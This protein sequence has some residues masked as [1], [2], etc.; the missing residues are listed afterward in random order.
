MPRPT[1][2]PPKD[3][4]ARRMRVALAE[5]DLKDFEVAEQASVSPEWLGSVKQGVTKNPPLDKLRAVAKVLGKP[6]SYFTAPLGYVPIEESGD[7]LSSIE[8]TILSEPTLSD[9]RKQAG[10]VVMRDLFAR[11]KEQVS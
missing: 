11:S 3:T 10:L 6:T 1:H 4:L 5:S 9:E 7:A 8:A 2:V